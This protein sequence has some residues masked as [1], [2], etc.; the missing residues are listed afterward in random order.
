ML[1]CTRKRPNWHKN[2]QNGFALDFASWTLTGA[3]T[4][5]L[6]YMAPCPQ[7]ILTGCAMVNLCPVCLHLYHGFLSASLCSEIIFTYSFSICIILWLTLCPRM[8]KTWRRAG[9]CWLTST[10]S[11]GSMT[12]PLNCSNAAY[13]TTRLDRPKCC[14]LLCLPDSVIV[15]TVCD[16]SM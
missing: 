15:I 13:S 6:T 3:L 9:C 14:L 7:P 5:D 12:W 10:S 2:T 8:L 16:W 4:L 1:I 11:L